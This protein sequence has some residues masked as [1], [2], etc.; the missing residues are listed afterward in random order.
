MDLIEKQL[1]EFFLKNINTDKMYNTILDLIIMFDFK[2]IIKI[3]LV[4]PPKKTILF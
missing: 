1:L 4:K 3:I 2:I